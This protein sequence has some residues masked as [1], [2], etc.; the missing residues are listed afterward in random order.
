MKPSIGRREASRLV[1]WLGLVTAVA[2]AGAETL[3]DA[4]TLAEANDLGLAAA[5]TEAEAAEL[6][7]RAARWE[8]RPLLTATGSFAQ[9]ADAPAFSFGATALPEIFNHA[10]TCSVG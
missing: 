10:T 9:L 8:R 1:L 5:R 4:W 2:R 3:E 6:D 7:A